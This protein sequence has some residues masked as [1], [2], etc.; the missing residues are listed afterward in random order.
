ME[1]TPSQYTGSQSVQRNNSNKEYLG[2]TAYQWLVI[3]AA[4]LGWGFDIFDALLFNY[5]SRLCIPSLLG[6]TSG[7]PQ[8]VTFW[9]GAL[10]SV[11]L[12]GWGVGGIIFGKL[13]D[14][15]GRTR[16]LMFTMMTYALATAACAMAPN[17]WVLAIFRFIASLGVGGEW[18]AGAA[19]VAE[20]VPESKRVK[21]GAILYTASPFGLF[22]ATFVTDL[23]TRQ[24][25][26]I[27]SNTDMSW[28]LVFLTGL[29]PAVIAILIRLKVKEPEEWT[30]Q[31]F[32][33]RIREL[34][35]PELRAKTIGGT[36]MAAVALITWWSCNAFLPAIASFLVKD[37]VPAPPLES[38]A[39]LKASFVTLGTTVF[40]LGGLIGTLLT[41]PI[42]TRLGRRPMFYIYFAL[43]TFFIWIIFQAPLTPHTRLLLMFF[44]GLTV[45][46]IFGAFPFYLPELFPTRLRG[47]GSGFSYNTARFIT[48]IGPFLVG[49]LAAKAVSSQEILNVVSWVA[50]VPAA[51]V[52][53]LWMGVGAET[54]QPGAVHSVKSV[55]T[56]D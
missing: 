8:N 17:I 43:S 9:T 39:A 22:L 41:I 16:T 4:W 32:H 14:R 53:L 37:V 13:T 20:S 5:V 18:A 30:P 11:L 50:I 3:F 27:A 35:T 46:G 45:F 24:L 1:L 51:G 15:F 40:N 33:P 55:R 25:S 49:G 28:R 10:T 42:A 38:V 48:A 52:V 36:C 31:K 54:R 26:G 21:A 6:D 12:I 7:D 19:L 44:P 2:F 56:T 34:F 29:I 47:T 23:F